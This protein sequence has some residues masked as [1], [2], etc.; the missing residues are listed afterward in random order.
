MVNLSYHRALVRHWNAGVAGIPGWPN[1]R[2]TEPP[3]ERRFS[4][5][6]LG[7]LCPRTAG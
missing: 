7:E 5:P 6:T 3:Y 2:L 4:G 1:F